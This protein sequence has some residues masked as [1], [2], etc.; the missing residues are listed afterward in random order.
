MRKFNKDNYLRKLKIKRFFRNNSRY[1]YIA[2]TC[3]LCCFLGIYFAYSKFFVSEEQEIIR[4]TVGDF[5]SGDVILTTYV[6][7]VKSD[8]IPEKGTG[9]VHLNTSCD[10]EAVSSWSNTDWKLS[11]FNVLKKTKCNVY[12]GTG[13]VTDFDYSGKEEI[14]VAPVTGL[15]RIEA[16]GGSG[17]NSIANGVYQ[18]TGGTG[19]YS[20]GEIFLLK[21]TTIYV[22]VGGRGGDGV[23]NQNDIYGGYNG[24]G[25]SHWDKRDDEA[26]GSGGGATHIATVSGLLSTLENNKDSILIVAGAGGGGGGT[27]HIAK[28][29]GLLSDLE[30]SKDDIIIVAAGGGGGSWINIGGSG[31]GLTGGDGIQSNLGATQTSGYKFGLGGDGADNTGSPGGGGGSG[32]YGGYGGTNDAAGGGG[33]SG[34]IG[35]SLLKDKSM[36]CYNCTESSVESTKTVTTTCKEAMPTENCAKKGDGYAKITFIGEN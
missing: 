24:G 15:Y 22:N 11:I 2:L 9:Y 30:N 12:F 32:Y 4:T 5:R 6:N 34:Y 26:S 19:G 23:L 35:N 25:L 14:F 8:K 33:G 31:G 17:G 20:I 10:N 21:D 7:G 28:V 18:E 27:T 36:Y 1:F 3:L 29:S 13:S 16:W